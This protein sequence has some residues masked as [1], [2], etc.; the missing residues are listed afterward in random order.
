MIQSHAFYDIIVGVEVSHDHQ[1]SRRLL[2]DTPRFYVAVMIFFSTGYNREMTVISLASSLILWTLC[3]V[4][5]V[6]PSVQVHIDRPSSRY[7]CSM[8][9]NRKAKSEKRVVCCESQIAD[10]YVFGD[11][12]PFRPTLLKGLPLV[13]S[14]FTK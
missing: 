4:A 6:F 13:Q 14:R 10:V 8:Y 5:C 3:I 1:F 9:E 11:M 12:C 7:T 2:S